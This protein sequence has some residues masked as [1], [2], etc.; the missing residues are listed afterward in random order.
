MGE[1]EGIHTA[2]VR[3]ATSK[4]RGLGGGWEMSA[5]TLVPA[6]KAYQ[7]RSPPSS[8]VCQGRGSRRECSGQF[9]QMQPVHQVWLLD[10]SS[11]AS[12]S[13]HT[14]PPTRRREVVRWQ[15]EQLLN[16]DLCNPRSLVDWRARLVS[17]TAR[18]E[19]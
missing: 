6:H 19:E 9:S 12:R 10:R 13:P 18:I 15:V 1:V 4:T 11:R 8:S 14:S 17:V 7:L 5:R 2:M 16:V 3:P